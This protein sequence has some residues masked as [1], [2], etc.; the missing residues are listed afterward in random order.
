MI[1]SILLEF[2]IEYFYKW[3]VK[4]F[5]EGLNYTF[6]NFINVFMHVLLKI[7]DVSIS[8]QCSFAKYILEAHV[9]AIGYG[10]IKF[11]LAFSNARTQKNFYYWNSMLTIGCYTYAWNIYQYR[12]LTSKHRVFVIT[13]W[14]LACKPILEAY[15]VLSQFLWNYAV[16]VF[17]ANLLELNESMH[18]YFIL[19]QV[20]FSCNL[21]SHA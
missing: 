8:Y 3:F 14:T 2:G 10:Y 13:F 20:N 9:Y 5:N 18:E 15:N 1:E 21:I 4:N 7:F 11:I 17:H 19:K 12:L 6:L 16:V